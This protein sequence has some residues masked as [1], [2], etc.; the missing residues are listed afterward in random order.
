MSNRLETVVDAIVEG[1]RN[2]LRDNNVTMEEYRKG[3]QFMAET[4]KQG[5]IPLLI[6]LYINTTIVEIANR[7]REGSSNDL[8]GPYFLPDVPDVTDGKIKVMEEFG[9]DPM[10]LRGQ[11]TDTSGAP[12]PHATMFI[13]NSTPDGKYSG[14]HDDISPEYYRGKLQTDENGNYSVES[15]VPVPYQIPNQGKVGQLLEMMGKH[16][17]RPA[18]VHY[19]VLKEGFKDLT[20]QA[21]FEGGDWVGDDCASGMHTD[22]FVMPHVEEDGKKIMEVNFTIDKAA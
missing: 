15:T 17:W 21:Y 10:I 9:G 19:K 7:D 12:V 3:M 11:V 8:Q 20:T 16:S 2:A 18:H 14:F 6:D 13:W 1:V 5:E 4:M 22:E